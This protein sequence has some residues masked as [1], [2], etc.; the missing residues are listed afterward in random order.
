M[1]PQIEAVFEMILPHVKFPTHIAYDCTLRRPGCPLVQVAKGCPSALA[2]AFP[3]EQWLLAPTDD[4]HVYPL[5]DEAQLAKLLMF[6]WEDVNKEG[7]P[8]IEGRT[9]KSLVDYDSWV[10]MEA[11]AEVGQAIGDGVSI[12]S[13]TITRLDTALSSTPSGLCVICKKRPATAWWTESMH[14]HVHG[15]SEARCEL[16]C[17]DEQIAHAE[18]MVVSLLELREKRQKL[19]DADGGS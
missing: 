3:L 8:L 18:K 6:A 2:H 7:E 17:L 1:S 13:T 11:W 4:L 12:S 14:A 5:E 10:R 19:L 9:I 16:C 15:L